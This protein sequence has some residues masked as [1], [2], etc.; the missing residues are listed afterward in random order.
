M[1]TEL[2]FGVNYPFKRDFLFYLFFYFK[3]LSYHRH[4]CC[5]ASRWLHVMIFVNH[6]LYFDLCL[7]EQKGETSLIIPNGKNS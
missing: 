2:Y 4:W 1:M 5:I 7:V 6:I 3:K